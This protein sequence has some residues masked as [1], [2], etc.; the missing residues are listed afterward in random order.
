MKRKREMA[1]YLC[2]MPSS[3]QYCARGL[4]LFAPPPIDRSQFPIRVFATWHIESVFV[5]L[6]VLVL[7]FTATHHEGDVVR[8]GPSTPLDGNGDVSKGHRVVT[9]ADIRASVPEII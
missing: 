5:F 3:A 6:C 8:V 4:E 1:L 9:D 7:V 2:A